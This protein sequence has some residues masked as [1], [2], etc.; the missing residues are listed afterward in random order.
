MVA[1]TTLVS[2]TRD[3]RAADSCVD[4]DTLAA[5]VDGALSDAAVSR[6]DA[7]IDRCARCR[8]DLSALAVAAD[9]VSPSLAGPPELAAESE[10][11]EAGTRIGRYVV[12]NHHGRGGMG[13]VVR[14]YD[15]ELDRHVAIKLLHPEMWDAAGPRAR[16]RLKREAQAM[17]RLAHA[18]VVRVHDVGTHGDQ[19]FLA[20]EFIDGQTLREWSEPRTWREA[21]AAC[22]DAGRGLVA[23]HEAQ[24]VH[25]DFKPANV[26]CSDDGRVLVTDFGLARVEQ[27]ETAND[28]DSDSAASGDGQ[29]TETRTLLGTP[30]YMAPELYDGQPATEASDQ[31]AFCVTAFEVLHRTRPFSGD[32]QAQ[33]R[34]RIA[35]GVAIDPPGG[36]PVPASVDRALRRGMSAD[37]AERYESMA[38]LLDALDPRP[39][40]RRRR[41]LAALAMVAAIAGALVLGLYARDGDGAMCDVTAEQL[42]GAWDADRRAA[43]EA[44]LTA[45]GR[46]G[47][48]PAFDR[49]AELLDDYAARW[50]AV[51][52]DA[53][54][55]THIRGEQSPALLDARMACLDRR[56]RELGELTRLLAE[57][58]DPSI[59]DR[60]VE[61]VYA[62][63]QPGSC[64]AESAEHIFPKPDDPAERQRVDE[65]LAALDTVAALRATSDYDAAD[66]VLAR[67]VAV[68]REVDYPPLLAEALY[69]VGQSD[70]ERDRLDE[71]E[72]DLF[73]AMDAAAAAHNDTFVADLWVNLIMVAGSKSHR[74][75]VAMAYANAAKVAFARVDPA[76]ALWARLEYAIGATQLARGDFA[77]A[78]ARFERALTYRDADRGAPLPQTVAAIL[79]GLCDVHRIKT[80]LDE[81][82]RFCLDA[83][84]LFEESLGASHPKTAVA[85]NSLGVVELEAP[86]YDA[87]K[88]L[89]TRA[90]DILDRTVGDKSVTRALAIGNLGLI[91]MY[92]GDLDE[93]ERQLEI[94]RDVFERHHPEHP[95]R[96]ITLN[97]LATVSN[98]RGEYDSA[99][100]QY[101]EVIDLNTEVYGP[102]S[103]GVALSK[104]NLATVYQSMGRRGEA[105]DMLRSAIDVAAKVYGPNSLVAA[106]GYDTLAF[107]AQADGDYATAI[108]YGERALAIAEALYGPEH[109]EAGY[110]LRRLGNL[111]RL[112]GQRARAVE[113][114]ERAYSI[115]TSVQSMA[116]ET[117]LVE[118]ALARALW[119]AGGDRTRAVELAEAA[120]A[121]FRASAK[122]GDDAQLVE[123]ER[124]L[125]RHKK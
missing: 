48:A 77:A 64:D 72:G 39:A 80:R 93:A 71:A 124:W 21:L 36:S 81:A 74:F 13:L 95:Q 50:V 69:R 78:Q 63:H 73:E 19:I 66:E 83:V 7:H 46:D 5:Y 91:G 68:A 89:F 43:V 49:V 108:D 120:T 20:M 10:P 6:V 14:A 70:T 94:A 119:V 52:A 100:A 59:V 96:L 65:A 18:N 79:G 87:A 26:L 62:L 16:E 117:G 56:K 32:N 105:E 22:I 15:P 115:M 67:A 8:A 123:A 17:A 114:L 86:D 112:T 98:T 125:A 90:I 106:R 44:A 58:T 31:F 9:T 88:R 55:A 37:P 116:N 41:W 51:R 102:E 40:G 76:P 92:V 57:A 113:V 4:S 60:A 101:V 38:A 35:A 29:L 85:L 118:F 45:T 1:R 23:A 42:S 99:I 34:E 75:D 109:P 104:Y 121:R 12:L 2:A 47:A 3:I 27:R 82:R 97:N 11:L 25:R 33:L 107:G 54:E 103:E 110:I 28:G 61:A 111:Y 122:S 30:A 53:C 24:L 84:T